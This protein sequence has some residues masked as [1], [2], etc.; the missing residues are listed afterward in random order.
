MLFM[1]A[2][3]E[4]VGASRSENGIDEASRKDKTQVGND[5]PEATTYSALTVESLHCQSLIPAMP[6]NWTPG[7]LRPPLAD[8]KARAR[9]SNGENVNGDPQAKGNRA[10]PA[11]ATLIGGTVR[12]GDAPPVVTPQKSKTRIGRKDQSR[13]GERGL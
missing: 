9:V 10:A 7:E 12:A 6:A 11:R 8:E 1:R 5:G 2:T 13:V 4:E 3:G